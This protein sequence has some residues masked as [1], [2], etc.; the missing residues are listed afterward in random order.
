VAAVVGYTLARGAVEAPA[1]IAEP[2]QA[3]PEPEPAVEAHGG[4]R[5]AI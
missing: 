5:R 3:Q 2:P 1:Q 4:A